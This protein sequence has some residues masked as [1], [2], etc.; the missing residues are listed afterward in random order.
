MSHL[1]E[2][3]EAGTGWEDSGGPPGKAEPGDRGHSGAAV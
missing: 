3:G 1:R 2:G